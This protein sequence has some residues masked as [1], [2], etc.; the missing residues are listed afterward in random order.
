LALLRLR[1]PVTI[2][3]ASLAL[4]FGSGYSNPRHF[5]KRFL[6]YLRSVVDYYPDVRLENTTGGLLLKPSPTHVERR[7]AR[8][9]WNSRFA[10]KFS[11]S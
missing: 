11:G 5:K 10:R 8:P 1:K 6:G 3:W 4:Q 9:S 2:P 7:S